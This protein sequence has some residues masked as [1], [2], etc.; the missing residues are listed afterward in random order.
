MPHKRKAPAPTK[1]KP[2]PKRARN[3]H[4]WEASREVEAILAKRW[5]KGK[6]EYHTKW[7]DYRDS[8]N[9]CVP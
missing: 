4:P 2:I 3:Q 6:K 9:T 7:V 5:L 8:E 1:P